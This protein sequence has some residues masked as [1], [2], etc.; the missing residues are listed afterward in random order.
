GENEKPAFFNLKYTPVRDNTGNVMGVFVTGIDITERIISQQALLQKQI[1]L[2]QAETNYREIFE[3]ANEGI[4]VYDINSRLVVEANNK[5][6]ELVGCSKELFLA[7]SRKKFEA[8][9]PGYEVG[10]ALQKFKKAVKG[11]PQLFEWLITRSD[12]KQSWMEVSLTSAS[13][14]GSQ[15]ILAFFR[16]INDRKIA[17]QEKEFEKVDKEALINSTGDLIWSVSKEFNL[18]AANEAFIVSIEKTIGYRLK[19]GDNLLLRKNFPDDF[20]NFWEQLYKRTFGGEKF[21]EVVYTPASSYVPES[22]TEISFNP[23]VQNN[24]IVFIAC[25][26]RNISQ[27]KLYQQQ[28]QLANEKLEISQQVAKLGLWELDLTTNEMYCSDETY[29][30]FGLEKRGVADVF[31]TLVGIIHP[32]DRELFEAE[33]RYALIGEKLLNVEHRIT[34]QTG[35]VKTVIQ[36]GSVLYDAA[37]NPTRFSGTIQDI[38]E[39]KYMEVQLWE[40]QRQLDLIY[41]TVNEIIFLIDVEEGNRFRFQSVNKAFLIST[42]LQKEQVLNKF[43]EEVIPAE[44]YLLVLENYMKAIETG[45]SV[46]WDETSQYPTGEKTGIVTV[47]PIFNDQEHCLQL[48]GSIHDITALKKSG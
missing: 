17:E 19:P 23:V 41:N 48:I 10:I 22:W 4:F 8:K 7:S 35:L 28:L 27:N 36:R 9:L 3:K 11:E 29:R 37:N 42:G 31:K 21:M 12:H 5:A 44:S 38:T 25:Y 26:S 43:I 47:T 45:K 1:E 39:R 46:S 20:I 15:R 24:E 33:F 2:E 40:S 6:C 13:I 18:I 32:Q 16:D 30:I 14:A 34:T